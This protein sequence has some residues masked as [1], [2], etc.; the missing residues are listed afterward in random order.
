MNGELIIRILSILAIGG[1]LAAC[2]ADGVSPTDVQ[3]QRARTACEQIG[4]VAGS[5]DVSNCATRLQAA[6]KND[7]L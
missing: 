2:T 3:M 7:A 1:G 6:L 5:S 4:L